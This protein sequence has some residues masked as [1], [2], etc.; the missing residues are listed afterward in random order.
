MVHCWA[1]T[2]ALLFHNLLNSDCW[3]KARISEG[4]SHP[5]PVMVT[6]PWCSQPSH[7]TLPGH[8]LMRQHLSSGSIPRG[9]ALTVAPMLTRDSLLSGLRFFASRARGP[10]SLTTEGG[11]GGF[12]CPGPHAWHQPP[13][14]PPFVLSRL[15]GEGLW[16]QPQWWLVL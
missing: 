16:D 10:S 15:S 8:Q 11:K 6:S 7:H 1:E 9:S 4:K 3:G 2:K 13:Q 5:P 14:G 12:L